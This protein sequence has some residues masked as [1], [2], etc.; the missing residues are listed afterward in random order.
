[1]DEAEDTRRMLLT[2]LLSLDSGQEI[3]V[4]SPIHKTLSKY[5]NQNTYSLLLITFYLFYL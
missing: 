2:I 4:D 3:Q 1:M 5:F